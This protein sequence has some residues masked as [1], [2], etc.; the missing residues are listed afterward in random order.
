MSAASSEIPRSAALP[1]HHRSSG[2]AMIRP[3]HQPMLAPRKAARPH[4]PSRPRGLRDILDRSQF[5]A[6]LRHERSRSD[7]EENE[8][9]LVLIKIRAATDDGRS[10]RRV[11]RAVLR[12][13]RDTDE[14][15]WY[16]EGCL[17]VLLPN[18][19]YRG[20]RTFESGIRRLAE[21][22]S[23]QVVSNVYTYP[24]QWVIDGK[25]DHPGPRLHR[26]NDAQPQ[27]G[28]VAPHR[29]VT[30]RDLLPYV[31]SGFVDALQTET[32]GLEAIESLLAR[33]LPWWKR[34]IDIIAAGSALLVLAPLMSAIAMLIKCG[35]PGP[36]MFGQWR[37]GLG[38]KPFWIYK[39]RTMIPDAEM[40]KANLRS[41]S[42]QDG[43]AF[44]MKHDPRITPIGRVLRVTSLDELPQL[45][46]VLKGD[47]SLV[48]PRP[49]P[50]DESAACKQWQ[51]RR[52][53]LTPGL[54]CIWQVKGRSRVTF[55]EWMRMDLAY[56][57]TRS[58]L[59]DI[60]IILQ[61]IPAVLLRRGAR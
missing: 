44:K 48:G 47:M 61:T 9:S 54:T 15:G 23:I 27:T 37:A 25:S 35:S 12:R 8:F 55:V 21:T 18:T 33:P 2:D 16:G 53:D 24:S 10:H 30:S 39:F 14:V 56:A 31:L 50:L 22:E 11:A 58:L 34:A 60:R 57:R 38:G 20:G 17:C 41:K 43:P 19:E 59:H 7:R 42:E 6:V 28:V 32:L 36:I 1:P 3:Q 46:N 45:W 5:E 29:G 26:E 40:H 52:L 4:A 49:L 13:L 51:K